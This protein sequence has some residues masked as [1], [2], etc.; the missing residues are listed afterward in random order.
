M[1]RSLGENPVRLRVICFVLV[2]VTTAIAVC[3]TGT[4]GF[5]GLVAPHIAR[6][7]VGSDNK[8]LI[9]VSAIL[10]AIMII[11]TDCMVRLLPGGLPAGVMTAMIGAPIFVIILYRQRRTAAF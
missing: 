8:M 4:I 6:L 1:A 3:Y 10:G 5:V 11:A 2:S 9:P 7:F